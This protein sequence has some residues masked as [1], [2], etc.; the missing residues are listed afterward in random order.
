MAC[1]RGVIFTKEDPVRDL[2]RRLHFRSNDGF[3]IVQDLKLDRG[4]SVISGLLSRDA[5]SHAKASSR[6][7]CS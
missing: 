2:V 3:C 6:N 7:L 5:N 1:H 4:E